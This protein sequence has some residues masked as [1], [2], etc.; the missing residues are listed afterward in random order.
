MKVAMLIGELGQFK[1]SNGARTWR[2]WAGSRAAAILVGVLLVLGLFSMTPPDLPPEPPTIESIAVASL[3]PTRQPILP[4]Q[5]PKPTIAPPPLPEP[6]QK[7]FV[8]SK[9][10]ETAKAL[11]PPKQSTPQAP[12]A[13]ISQRRP[14]LD[15]PTPNTAMTPSKGSSRTQEGGP[16]S[17]AP[18]IATAPTSRAT[19]SSPEAGAAGT[20][21]PAGTSAPKALRAGTIAL[22]RARECA[23]LDVRDRPADCPPNEELK[24]LLAQERGPHYRPENAEAFSRNEQQWR[25]IPPPCLEDG[26][27]FSASATGACIRFGN[28]PSRVRTVQEIC[29]ARGLGGCAPTPS[30]AAVNAAVA[31]AK[32]QEAAKSK[33]AP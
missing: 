15:R 11:S 3:D 21:G 7:P 4:L 24:R 18:R 19:P 20:A 29:E 8:A 27:N 9:Q 26:K 28:V 22:L 33:K 23:R 13:T 16:A 6:Q 31:Q 32:Q 10:S 5:T 30:Q 2:V 17:T 1:M 14:V 12:K 25:G